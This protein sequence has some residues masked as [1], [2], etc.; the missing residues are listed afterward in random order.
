MEVLSFRTARQT[1]SDEIYALLKERIVSLQLKPGEM[2]YESKLAE[3][4]GVSRTPVREAIS[5][6]EQEELIHILPQRGAY[7]AYLSKRKF[8]EA[9]FIR[10]T[11][12]LATLKQIAQQ[13]DKNDPVY[14][15]AEQDLL[16]IIEKQKEVAR[17]AKYVM[18]VELD[19]LFHTRLLELA[20]NQTLLQVLQMMRAHLHRMR[21]LELKEERHEWTSIQQHEELLQYVMN[22]DVENTEKCLLHHL[23]Y[24]AKDWDKITQKYAEYFEK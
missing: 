14:Q 13:W 15:K 2:I 7:I 19:A 22:N 8:H 18:Y 4:F 12:E 20:D 16:H 6:L 23:R 3:S 9:Q 21:Y 11:L 1:L 24:I 10:E 5:R 17:E